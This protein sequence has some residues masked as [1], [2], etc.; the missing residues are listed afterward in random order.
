MKITGPSYRLRNIKKGAK[1]IGE[2]DVEKET[3][4]N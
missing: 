3:K 1:D 2:K 4:T